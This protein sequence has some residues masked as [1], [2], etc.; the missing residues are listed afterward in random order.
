MAERT[1]AVRTVADKPF[2]AFTEER[3]LSV[4]TGRMRVT[5]MGAILAFVAIL[6]QRTANTFIDKGLDQTIREMY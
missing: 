5:V 3:T 1:L 4:G 6:Q 2:S